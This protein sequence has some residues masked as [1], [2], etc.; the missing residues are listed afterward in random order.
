METIEPINAEQQAKVIQRVAYYIELASDL[1]G[2]KFSD[3]DVVFNLRGKA[4]GMYRCYVPKGKGLPLLNILG[5]TSRPIKR[6]I[7]FN[8]W[9][10]AKYPEDSYDNTIPH[11]VAHYLSDCLY[12]LNK[13][14]PH[15]HE[16]KSI[17]QDLGA[18]PKVR[19]SYTLEGIPVRN[20][21]RYSYACACRHVQLT[22]YRHQKIQKGVQQYSCRDC[23]EVL[24]PVC[25]SRVLAG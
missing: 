19:G 5:V 16:W 20:I 12:G 1:Y 4:A 22:S 25:K 14:K 9:L 13:I 11:E 17:M 8:P 7:R 21:K 15:G 18:E 6:E 2:R 24:T 3:I 10:F 23:G